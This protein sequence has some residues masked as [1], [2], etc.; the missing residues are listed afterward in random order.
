MLEDG[1]AVPLL[2]AVK[3]PPELLVHTVDTKAVGRSGVGVG[4][5]TIV[6]NE[7]SGIELTRG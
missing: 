5:G 2:A 4:P 6:M 1:K 3:K 7:M